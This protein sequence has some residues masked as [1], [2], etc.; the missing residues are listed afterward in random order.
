MIFSPTMSTARSRPTKRRTSVQ[1]RRETQNAFLSESNLLFPVA[2]MPSFRSFNLGWSCLDRNRS[3]DLRTGQREY[4]FLR[5]PSGVP[6][7]SVDSSNANSPASARPTLD[8]AR[9]GSPNVTL[10][11][12]EYISG[13]DPI[14]EMTHP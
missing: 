1:S 4:R 2:R 12:I 7:P 8:L 9:C 11:Q 5:Q 10:D 6:L 3:A 13:D 14:S